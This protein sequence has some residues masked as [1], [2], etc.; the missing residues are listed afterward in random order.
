MKVDE[1][2]RERERERVIVLNPKMVDFHTLK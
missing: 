2:G 1:R